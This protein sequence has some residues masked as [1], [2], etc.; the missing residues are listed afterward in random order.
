MHE[1]VK[2]LVLEIYH[3]H[4]AFWRPMYN[5][6]TGNWENLKKDFQVKG[7]KVTWSLCFLFS[8]LDKNNLYIELKFHPGHFPDQ[9]T[10][11][12]SF[13]KWLSTE[14][15]FQSHFHF[16]ISQYVDKEIE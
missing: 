15:L 9:S 10:S 2:A 7:I 1:N 12:Y 5:L 6:Y 13:W 14:N 3:F 8:F 16:F 11:L 4:T